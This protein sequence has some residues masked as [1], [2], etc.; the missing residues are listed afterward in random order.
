MT[1]YETSKLLLAKK[2][3]LKAKKKSPYSCLENIAI[4]IVSKEIGRGI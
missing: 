2:E 4:L 3:C 1:R